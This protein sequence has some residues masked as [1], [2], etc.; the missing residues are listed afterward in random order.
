MKPFLVAKNFFLYNYF[1]PH[2]FNCGNTFLLHYH[3]VHSNNHLSPSEVNCLS[4]VLVFFCG[5]QLCFGYLLASITYTWKKKTQTM[6][7][8]T[9]F[10]YHKI[11][12]QFDHHD[13]YQFSTNMG[14]KCTCLLCVFFC[15]REGFSFLHPPWRA[16]S[17]ALPGTSQRCTW[18]L[19]HLRNLKTCRL[20][21]GQKGLWVTVGHWEVAVTE[22]LRIKPLRYTQ[23]FN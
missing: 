22:V 8:N 21:K 20:V 17:T 9:C 6:L 7:R 15:E 10:G 5:K 4:V 13:I 1:W 19:W 18:H 3:L 16:V 12:T 14:F 11:S 23:R 2:F